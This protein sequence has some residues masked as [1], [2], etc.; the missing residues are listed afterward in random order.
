MVG[1]CGEG[2]DGGVGAGLHILSVANA[3]EGEGIYDHAGES[4]D[5]GHYD[6]K[7]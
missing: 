3:G 6:R 1:R 7:W 4:D 2:G 5:Y